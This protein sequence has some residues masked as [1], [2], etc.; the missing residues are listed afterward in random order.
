[1]LNSQHLTAP[2]VYVGCHKKSK[3]TK[4]SRISKS[5]NL[6]FNLA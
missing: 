4:F 5:F 1:M 6:P 3:C 2:T